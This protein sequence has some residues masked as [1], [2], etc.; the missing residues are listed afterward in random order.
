MVSC[1]VAVATVRA[2]STRLGDRRSQSDSS[3]PWAGDYTIPQ[4][5]QMQSNDPDIGPVIVWLIDNR[6]PSSSHVARLSPCT[7]HYWNLWSTLVM[8]DGLLFRKFYRR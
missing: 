6:R 2:V 8:K 7:R 3:I 1:D 5:R 4:L